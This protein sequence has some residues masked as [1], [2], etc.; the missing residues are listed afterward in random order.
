VTLLPTGVAYNYIEATEAAHCFRNEVLAKYFF[1]E[2]AGDRQTNAVLR[3]N[4]RDD[5]LGVGLL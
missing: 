3:F 4:Q 2:V 5:F 1:A